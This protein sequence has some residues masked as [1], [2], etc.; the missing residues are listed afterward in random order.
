MLS[1]SGNTSAVERAITLACLAVV[2]AVASERDVPLLPG[3]YFAAVIAAG[4]LVWHARRLLAAAVVLV[5]LPLAWLAAADSAAFVH[6]FITQ[7]SRTSTPDFLLALC[8][9]AGGFVG[10]ALTATALA[11]VAREFR[12]FANWGRIVTTGTVA[13]AF[14]ECAAAGAPWP[15]HLDSLLPLF[16]VWQTSIAAAIGYGMVTREIRSPQAR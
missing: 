10:S 12:A 16:L 13:G 4:F 9:V 7:G 15:I 5:A 11:A 1:R 3:V 14:L 2:S 8:G 6:E